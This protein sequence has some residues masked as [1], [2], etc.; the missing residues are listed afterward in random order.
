VDSRYLYLF[1]VVPFAFKVVWE[2]FKYF[3]ASQNWLRFFMWTN[4]SMPVFLIATVVDKWHTVI[5]N[6]RS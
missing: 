4:I 6:I 2:F 1:L 3:K 5:A